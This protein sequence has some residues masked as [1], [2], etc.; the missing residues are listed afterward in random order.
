MSAIESFIPA[1]KSS[2]LIISAFS[3]YKNRNIQLDGN[4]G[5]TNLKSKSKSK[6]VN[7]I[8][9]FYIETANQK[10]EYGRNDHSSPEHH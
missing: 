4:Y 6:S 1:T 2:V 5:N 9:G 8:Y 3:T 7:H 10:N